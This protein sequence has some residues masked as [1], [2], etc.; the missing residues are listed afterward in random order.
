MGR[1]ANV[2]L[3]AIFYSGDR[4]SSIAPVRLLEISCALTVLQVKAVRDSSEKYENVR[5]IKNEFLIP[6]IDF[7]VKFFSNFA[8]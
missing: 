5:F 4:H 2:T 7:A 1:V 6:F 3:L 8:F